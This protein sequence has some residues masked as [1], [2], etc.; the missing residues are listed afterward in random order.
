MAEKQLYSFLDYSRSFLGDRKIEHIFELGARDCTETLEFHKLMPS[1]EIY[2]FECNPNTLKICRKKVKGKKNIHLVESAVSNKNEKVNFYPINKDK[3]RTTWKDGNQGA[4]S[5]FKASGKYPVEHY[6]QDQTEVKS[7]RLDAFMTQ[8][9]IG[10]IDLLWMDIQ[11][12]ELL[13]L[14]GLGSKIKNVS[15]IH[16]EVEFF[17]IYAN[18]PL[19]IDIKRFLNKK[20]FLLASFTSFGQYSG[21]AVFVNIREA[22]LLSMPSLF[23]RNIALYRFKK[24]NP[25]LIKMGAA[26]KSTLALTGVKLKKVL[27]KY[28]MLIIVKIKS[29]QQYVS[30]FRVK[31][32][33]LLT[34][35]RLCCVITLRFNEFLKLDHSTH[36]NDD[37]A[38]IKI[39]VVI[40]LIKKDIQTILMAVEGV[41][42]NLM[43]EIDN[44]YVVS[45]N[46]NSIKGICSENGL[47]HINENSLPIIQKG[48]IKY[49]SS[50]INRSGWL[51]QQ[52]IKL[53]SDYISKKKYVLVLDADTIMCRPQRLIYK[54]KIIFNHSTEYNEP[55]FSRYRKLLGKNPQ[56]PLS[57]VA[58]YMMIDTD[59]LK[60]LKM[61]IRKNF[62]K[63][64]DV[65]ICENINSS[66]FSDFSEYETYGN[67]YCSVIKGYHSYWYNLGLAGKKPNKDMV[68]NVALSEKTKSLSYH[69]YEK[70]EI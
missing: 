32:R 64:W 36:G 41:R 39:D 50:G 69:V 55:Y 37:S 57:F 43:H 45:K 42:K 24:V 68:S 23:F 16:T 38:N 30:L 31:K 13:A 8:K 53:S 15:I 4:S 70:L 35:R 11:G 9:R 67:Y 20:G 10:R 44:I 34:I 2:A 65:A 3:T 22:T 25:F 12:S 54:N 52:L 5:L 18:Q 62:K 21:D 14:K 61:E 56:Y 29:V 59:V 40:P 27:L 49:V 1:A 63:T 46:D 51:F 28:P 66:N 47:L 60:S 17:E 19:F 6:V 26:L 7:I 58:H 48:D 33:P